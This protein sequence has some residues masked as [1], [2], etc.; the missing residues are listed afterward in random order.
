MHEPRASSLRL[1]WGES[2][3]VRLIAAGALS[4]L[5]VS[6]LATLAGPWLVQYFVNQATA[7]SA[8]SVL[9]T[10]ALGYLAAALVA[11][12]ARIWASYLAVQAGWRIADSLRVRLLRHAAVEQPVLDVESRP[13]GEILE[14][15]E[16]NAN[17]VGK[18]IAESGFRML[19][20]I[21]LAIG[22]I[23]AMSVV[24]PAAGLAI[25]V[26]V[27]AVCFVLTRLTRRSVRR[28][29]AAREQ[30]AD[31]FGFVGD[32]LSARDDLL[33]ARES[34]WATE[35]TRTDLE[36]LLRTEGR[37]Y[38]SGRAFW[39]LTQLCF[40]LAFGLGFGFG[41]QQLQ[42]GAITIGTLTMIYLYVDLLQRPLEEMSSQLG[43]LQ[44]M[45]AVLKT[46]ARRLGPEGRA[47]ST[48][49]PEGRASLPDGRA[50]LPEGPLEVAFEGVCF[51]YGETQ[52]LSDVTFTV[53]PGGS[54]GIV[55][56]TGAGKS[57][58]VNLLCALAEPGAGRVLIGGVEAGRLTPAQFAERVTV[59]SQRAHV[60]SATVRENIT[61]FDDSMPVERVW[62]VLEQL[63]AADRVRALP[64]GLETRVGAGARELSDG[65]MQVLSGARALIR[66][67]SLL[68]VDEAASHFDP[69]TEKA[70]ADMLDTVMQDRTVVMVE[71]RTGT[72]R[73]VDRIMTMESGRVKEITEAGATGDGAGRSGALTRGGNR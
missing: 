12:A 23:V 13:V 21:A 30:Q 3:P 56:P 1:L 40:A 25:S 38:I 36:A 44:Q 6:V 62:E 26:L 59:L 27:I 72:L 9:V 20:N 39:P 55:G 68:I 19:S 48:A 33:L 69:E 71:H 14:Q 73:G 67:Y 7:G 54:L 18:A 32:S 31:L 70:W 22:T 16:G 17:I 5:M 43:Q 35:R 53:A 63:N 47:K 41:L 51:G 46:S 15:V 65:E 45:M 61:L 49:P 64:E 66:P 2:R 28:W 60:F 11:G 58:V 29:Q 8:Q 50:S 52:V 10:A 24:I 4:V 37:A 34:D 42:A 57:T